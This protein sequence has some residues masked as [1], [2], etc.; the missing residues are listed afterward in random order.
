MKRFMFSAAVASLVLMFAFFFLMVYTKKYVFTTLGITSMTICY[1]FTIRLVIGSI[2]DKISLMQFNPDSWRF[3]ERKF[4][5]KLYKALHVKKWKKFAL[6]YDN[7]K[8]DLSKNPTEDVI[9]ECC[10]AESVHWLC[11][12]A[13]LVSISFTAVFDSLLAFLI[14]GIAGALF[15][16]IFVMVQRY[17]R[18]RLLRYAA[19]KG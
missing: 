1:H 12:A 9:G 17:N 14:T 6:T 18:P 10:R 5:K 16:L 19:K 13:S 15:D 7:S 11:I 4:E 8:F 3:R 2:M